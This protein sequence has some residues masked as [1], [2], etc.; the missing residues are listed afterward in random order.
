MPPNDGVLVPVGSLGINVT[1]DNG[2]DI[3]GSSNGAFALLKVGSTTS[4]YQINLTTG[5]AT[6]VANININATAL[7][8]GLGF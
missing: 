2:F 7:A 8:L 6:S 4:L 1:S 3:G 5:Q